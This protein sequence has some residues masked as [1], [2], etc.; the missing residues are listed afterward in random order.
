[1][2]QLLSDDPGLL[3]R[4]ACVLTDLHFD[5]STTNGV[6]VDQ[7]LKRDRPSLPTLLSSDGWISQDK[8]TGSRDPYVSEG[9][10]DLSKTKGVFLTLLDHDLE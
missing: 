8:M 10:Y 4:L 5:N 1:M 2:T 9:G 7:K 3:E 6:D